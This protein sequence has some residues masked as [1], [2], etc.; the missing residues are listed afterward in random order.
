[1][2]SALL[3]TC[4]LVPSHLRDVLLETAN[5]GVYRALW[6]EEILAELERTVRML[7]AQRGND[8]QETEVYI[9]RLLRQM[10]TAFPDAVVEGWQPLVATFDLPDPTQPLPHSPS[11]TR[12]DLEN[13]RRRA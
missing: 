10:R 8:G 7:R 6:S 3:D 4:V 9:E 1:V 13:A 5:R 2:F 11:Q 12:T